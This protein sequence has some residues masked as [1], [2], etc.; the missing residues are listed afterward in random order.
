MNISKWFWNFYAALWKRKIIL[1]VSTFCWL[2]WKHLLILKIVLIAGSEFLFQPSFTVIGRFSCTCPC[3]SRL[4][5]Q[6]SESK[7]ILGTGKSRRV[8]T[9][10]DFQ[11]KYH[12]FIE[13]SRK[14][15]FCFHHN[16]GAKY[17]L[18]ALTK[19]LIWSVS[20]T[21]LY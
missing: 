11:N 16:K 14:S 5:D 12:H 21:T 7:A 1:I 18:K 13:A 8:T 9:R 10:K 17:V 6:F 19:V 4:S 3:H 20:D 15:I 2:L